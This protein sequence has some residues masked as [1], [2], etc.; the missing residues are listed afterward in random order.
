MTLKELQELG[1]LSSNLAVCKKYSAMTATDFEKCSDEKKKDV[2]A[3]VLNNSIWVATPHREPPVRADVVYSYDGTHFGLWKHQ[4]HSFTILELVDNSLV[5]TKNISMEERKMGNLDL[6]ESDLAA[7]LSAEAAKAEA[8]PQKMSVEGAAAPAP[9]KSDEEKAADKQRR[10]QARKE[11]EAR[12]EQ[13]AD[14]I[15]RFAHNNGTQFFADP[16]FVDNNR[17]YGRFLGFLVA[18]D[19]V[20][21]LSLKQTPINFGSAADVRYAKRQDVTL[22]KEQEERLAAGKSIGAKYLECKTDIVIR[23]AG[24]GSIIAGIVKTPQLTEISSYEVATDSSKQVFNADCAKDHTTILKVL[25][26]E[27]LYAYIELNYDKIIK[28]DES[29]KDNTRLIVKSTAVKSANA[30]KGTAATT[31]QYRTRIVADGRQLFTPGNYFP[32]ETYDTVSIAASNAEEKELLNNNFSA[33]LKQYNQKPRQTADGKLSTPKG[34]FSDEAN[35]MF[36]MDTSKSDTNKGLY[37]CTSAIV[38]NG[39]VVQCKPFG[40]RGKDTIMMDVTALPVRIVKEKKTGDSVS[41]AYRKSKFNEG[42]D[43][44]IERNEYKGF[45][46][47]VEAAADGVEFATIAASAKKA[48]RAASKPKTSTSVAD[49]ISGLDMLA[50]RS[51]K[52]AKV[53]GAATITDLFDAFRNSQVI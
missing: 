45:I 44:A 20:V 8:A 38:N 43:P 12:I 32:L 33:L 35:K 5:A 52:E 1:C 34:E 18:S 30:V 4:S 10:E 26:K 53:D 29:I 28:E 48:S 13:A 16:K 27:A 51:A 19:P 37:V 21:K 41:Y 9:K 50:L 36:T 17:R 22:T 23:Q 15:R 24:P 2:K 40:A 46:E 42:A 25:N 47:R 14:G 6:N 11:K 31:R 7:Q 39:A 49:R 3:V